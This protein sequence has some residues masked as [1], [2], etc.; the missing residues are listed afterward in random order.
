MADYD[1]GWSV[2]LD[3]ETEDL[4]RKLAEQEDRQIKVVIK[5]AVELYA[6]TVK[7]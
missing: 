5:R 7:K 4:V 3:R 2:K 6:K 1:K